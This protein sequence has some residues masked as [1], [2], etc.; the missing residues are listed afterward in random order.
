MANTYC[1]G[2]KR[3]FGYAIVAA[4]PSIGLGSHYTR[5]YFFSPIVYRV[6]IYTFSADSRVIF[7]CP[8]YEEKY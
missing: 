3:T 5:Q 6:F 1:Q 7:P 4:R 8:C 2:D